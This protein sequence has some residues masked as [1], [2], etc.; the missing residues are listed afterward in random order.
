MTVQ[1]AAT[2]RVHS[3]R[4]SCRID[5]HTSAEDAIGS[6]ATSSGV[7]HTDRTGQGSAERGE[8]TGAP[9]RCSTLVYE[10]EIVF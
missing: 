4:A 9:N 3:R 7:P 6:Q 8:N 2:G 5:M 1:H 10:R